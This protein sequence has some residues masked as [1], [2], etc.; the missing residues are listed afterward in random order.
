M[1]IAIDIGT[2]TTDAAIRH[3]GTLFTQSLPSAAPRATASEI[4]AL[5]ATE[6]GVAVNQID[7]IAMTGVGTSLV[8]DEVTGRRVF[9]ISE[10]DAIGAGGMHLAGIKRALVVS[11][12]TGTAMIAADGE[13]FNHFGGTGVGGGTLVGL[14]R[15]LLDVA[16]FEEIDA[17][18]QSGDISRVDLR[19]GDLVG[20]SLGALSAE[21]TA[22][23]FG[24]PRGDSTP[25]DIALALFNLVAESIGALS[26]AAARATNHDTI[27]M[28]GKLSGNR[29]FR[30]RIA[31]FNGIH[32]RNF[33]LPENP[34]SAVAIGALELAARRMGTWSA[35]S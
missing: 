23:N 10:F 20:G 29:I 28:V 18:A 5:L 14:G 24:K 7:R 30:T 19:I 1:I 25:A 35:G 17:L 6:A 8:P 11:I 2:T 15:R 4:L 13:R 27:V 16:R 9:K 12:G 26:L 31:R 22:S 34:G 3:N 32:G 33:V 21:A